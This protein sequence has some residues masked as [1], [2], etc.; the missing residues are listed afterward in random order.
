[1]LLLQSGIISDLRCPKYIWQGGE[2][3]KS[4]KDLVKDSFDRGASRDW[5]DGLEGLSTLERLKVNRGQADIHMM[6]LAETIYD[7]WNEADFK[8]LS[9]GEWHLPFGDQIDFEELEKTL[10]FLNPIAP[11][12]TGKEM[13]AD[14]RQAMLEI[15]VARCARLSYQTFGDNPRI[16]YAADLRLYKDLKQSGHW[17]PF[18][19]IAYAMSPDIWRQCIKTIINKEGQFQQEQGWL[20]NFRGWVQQ[21]AILENAA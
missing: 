4:W 20:A 5:V 6:A 21:R 10:V 11:I 18:E 14:I 7:A 17:S 16:D 3:F 1:M 19:H 15:C 8:E 9:P 13:R 12:M 2:T